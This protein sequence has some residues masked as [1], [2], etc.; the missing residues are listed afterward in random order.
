MAVDAVPVPPAAAVG[1]MRNV[2]AEAAIVAQSRD[3][4]KRSEQR[5][6]TSSIPDP[7]D[8]SIIE[9]IRMS[10]VH[11]YDVP[12]LRDMQESALNMLFDPTSMKRLLNIAPTGGGKTLVMKLLGIILKGV[13]EIS[14]PILALTA[15]Q[16]LKFATEVNKFGEVE[17]HN[18]D[19]ASSAHL[20][21]IATRIRNLKTNTTSTIFV[22][23]S[24]QFLVHNPKW[25]ELLLKCAVWDWE[26]SLVHGRCLL[27]AIH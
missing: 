16:V 12:Q 15:D 8:A 20:K 3:A 26:Y 24:P 6:P 22:F 2:A 11:V 14:H 10:S 9:L 18:L 27:S 21:R 4:L 7:D 5:Q 13:H 1:N 23:H 25:K 19:A 17:V